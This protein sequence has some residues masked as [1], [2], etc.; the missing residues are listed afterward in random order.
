MFQIDLDVVEVND[1]F[2]FECI[3]GYVW[4]SY[5]FQ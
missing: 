4:V 2:M 3:Y 5:D 1:I